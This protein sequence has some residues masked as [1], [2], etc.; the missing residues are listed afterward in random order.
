MTNEQNKALMR[1]FLEASI[2]D[3]QTA[4]RD[5]LAPDFVAHLSDGLQS[6]EA[7]L[8][9]TKVF[10]LAFNDRQFT[11]EDQVAEGDKIVARAT[12]QGTHSGDFQG[13]PPTGK[14]IM[15]GAFIIDR[16]KDGKIVEHWSLFDTMG[17]MQ[18]LGLVP[19]PQPP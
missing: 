18:Q 6:R 19:P 1:R 17:M 13:M 7:F 8:Q 3:D 2:A 14:R 11:V 4:F 9:Q 10:A 5:L 16:I 15:I 12:W